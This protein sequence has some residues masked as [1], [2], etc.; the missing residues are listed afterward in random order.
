MDRRHILHFDKSTKGNMM[1]LML[2]ISN[3]SQDMV[4]GRWS[5]T[6]YLKKKVENDL[7]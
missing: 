2:D 3:D 5:R 4:S 7:Q 6:S 1:H